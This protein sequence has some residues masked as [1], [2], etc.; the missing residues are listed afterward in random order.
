M[1]KAK[2]GVKK[3]NKKGR[4]GEKSSKS[5]ICKSLNVFPDQYTCN[6]TYRGY[7][8]I[9]GVYNA[10]KQFRLNSLYDPEYTDTG[11]QP[12]YFD[13][14]TTLY[15][16]YRVNMAS[17]LLNV[18][19]GGTT[20]TL[21]CMAGVN[22]TSVFD[23]ATAEELPYRSR[24]LVL[25]GN[26]AI[27]TGKLFKRFSPRLISGANKARYKADDV[28]SSQFDTNPG[29]VIL[30]NVVLE[31]CDHSTVI[32]VFVDFQMTFSATFFDRKLVSP[33]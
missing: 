18:T 15:N 28:Y 2:K 16:K 20:P 13:Q 5:L 21:V 30:L 24:V 7:F 10:D 1:K 17:M 9:S 33:S 23:I 22:S 3:G 25:G 27:S 6:L 31:A 32:T 4:G 26:S 12:R 11:S 8:T 14:L 29:E 19:N